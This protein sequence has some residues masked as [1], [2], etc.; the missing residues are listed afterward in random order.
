MTAT[1]ICYN[2]VGFRCNLPLR[3]WVWW[4]VRY[5]C[6]MFDFKK[7][8][9]SISTLTCP[10]KVKQTIIAPLTQSKLLL[11]GLFS[12]WLLFAG[13]AS[14]EDSFSCWGWAS[15]VNEMSASLQLLLHLGKRRQKKG[16]RNLWPFRPPYTKLWQEVLRWNT[17]R[18]SKLCLNHLALRRRR[19]RRQHQSQPLKKWVAGTIWV[20]TSQSMLA[21]NR[22]SFN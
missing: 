4:S 20:I 17:Q 18:E 22:D 9:M 14:Q 13:C 1:N 7:V 6:L 15:D 10:P 12:W 19:K 2:F 3:K 21:Y 8:K 5:A 16:T 11:G